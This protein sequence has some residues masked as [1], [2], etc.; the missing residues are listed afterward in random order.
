MTLIFYYFL[1]LDFQTVFF[2]LICAKDRA[3]IKQHYWYRR[4]GICYIDRIHTH[5]DEVLN[6]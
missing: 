3:W 5:N 2:P 4:K 6:S 1:R